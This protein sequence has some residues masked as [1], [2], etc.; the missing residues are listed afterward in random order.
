MY[1]SPDQ[2]GG[3]TFRVDRPD[4][5]QYLYLSVVTMQTEHEYGVRRVYETT[6]IGD[7]AI[8]LRLKD[9]VVELG[10]KEFAAYRSVAEWLPGTRAVAD[11]QAEVGMDEGRLSRFLARL[12]ESGLLYRRAALPEALS[13]EEF[14]EIFQA[15]LSSWLTEAFSH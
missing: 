2:P 3:R 5:G 11:L 14:H 1:L 13:G 10:A 7:G 4:G 8:A 9:R 12:A 15:S 6:T